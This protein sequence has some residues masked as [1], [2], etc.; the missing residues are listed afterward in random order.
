M[1]QFLR[2][3]GAL[4]VLGFA[5]SWVPSGFGRERPNL[6]LILTDDHR[7]D[8]IG[9]AGN[10]ILRTPNIDRL[11]A[12]GTLFTEATVTSA[13]CTPSRASIFTGMHERRHGINFNSGTALA[14]EAWQQTYPML[15][16]KA[17][18]F[19]GYIGKNHVPVGAMGY[20]TG[21]MDASFDFWFAGHEHL[22][23]YPKDRPEWALRVRGIDERM[24][25]NARAD[26][27]VEIIEE[28]VE[29]FL[30]PCDHF[31]DRASRFLEKRPKDRPFCLS[32]C[33]N[34]PHDAGAGNMKDRPGD[35]ELYKTGYYDQ[36]MAIRASLPATYTAKDGIR[37]PKLPANLLYTQYRQVGYNYV[38]TPEDCT[39]RIIRRYQTL[40]GID[41]MIGALRQRLAKLGLADSTIILF[42]SDH[43]IQLGEFGL[44]GKGLCYDASIRIPMIVY[45]PRS[46][47]GG[48]RRGEQVQ[49]IDLTATLLDYAGIP[50][51]AAMSG[52]S[53]RPLV[54][55]ESVPWRAHAFSENL[56][57]TPYGNP[58]IES[59]RGQGWKYIRYF[60]NDYALFAGT[61]AK[62]QQRVSNLQVQAYQEWLDAPIMGEAPVYEELFHLET[63]PLEAVNLASDPRHAGRLSELRTICAYMVAEVRGDVSQRPAVLQLE[64]ERLEYHR[65]R[66]Q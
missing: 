30:S 45:D 19:I 65:R 22:L 39:E 9:C 13:V 51:P 1:K 48:Q 15:L 29:N 25:H 6:I 23:F 52:R 50:V 41:R 49:T 16:R 44:G 14:P 4:S 60:K 64:C 34:L 10:P 12:E 26:T 53:L 18:Y 2:L 11:A 43:G 47:V 8:E 36:R 55:G 59:V 21:L 31:Y 5:G 63:D 54:I 40:T 37:S 28:G 58:R 62:G 27:Q 42:A 61:P 33:F 56:W 17:G 20:E 3:A 24:F 66:R 7:S 38:D 57:C 35:P 46:P 32:I